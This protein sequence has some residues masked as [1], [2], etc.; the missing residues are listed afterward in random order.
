M[1]VVQR[2]NATVQRVVAL[3]RSSTPTQQEN[4]DEEEA[5]QTLCVR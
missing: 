2:A 5:E 1:T 3:A 4:D